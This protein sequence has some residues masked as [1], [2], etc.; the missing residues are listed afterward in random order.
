MEGSGFLT[1]VMGFIM[2]NIAYILL[3]AG[4]LYF[5]FLVVGIVN[6]RKNGE[7]VVIHFKYAIPFALIIGFAVYCLA[8]GQD[9]R[10]FIN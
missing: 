4:L 3:G 5:V 9:L 1:T 7:A 2:A 6:A 8:T 10:T